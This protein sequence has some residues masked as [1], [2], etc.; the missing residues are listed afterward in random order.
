MDRASVAAGFAL[1]DAAGNAV[2]GTLSW[3]RP[4][5]L[6]FHPRTWLARGAAYSAVVGAGIRAAEGPLAAQAGASWSFTTAGLPTVSATTPSN[7]D[8]S[9]DMTNGLMLHFNAP[10]DPRLVRAH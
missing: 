6:V 8:R 10:V 2:P 1:R 5:T 9:A 7:G 4:D 3:P